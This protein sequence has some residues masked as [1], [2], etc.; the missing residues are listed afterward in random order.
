MKLQRAVGL[1]MYALG[2][3]GAEKE[4]GGVFGF[5]VAREGQ[6][7]FLGRVDVELGLVGARTHDPVAILADADA[8]GGCSGK[9]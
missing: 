7:Q 2:V 6:R 8:V 9:S 1:E 5:C 4:E 3:V